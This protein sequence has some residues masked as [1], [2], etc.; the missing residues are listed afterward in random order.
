MILAQSRRRTATHPD[1]QKLQDGANMGAYGKNAIARNFLVKKYNIVDDYDTLTVP[2]CHHHDV[3]TV[4]KNGTTEK[5][6]EEG[7]ETL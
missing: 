3:H 7:R 1:H 2:T 4:M 6:I 5:R